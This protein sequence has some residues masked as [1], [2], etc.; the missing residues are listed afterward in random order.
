[1]AAGDRAVG[2][3]T[4]LPKVSEG[5]D[6]APLLLEHKHPLGSARYSDSL[7]AE[8]SGFVN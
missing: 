6:A 4:N 3:L 2:R 7:S 8:H 5:V 1:M